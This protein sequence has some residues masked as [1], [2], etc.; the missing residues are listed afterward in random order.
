[1]TFRQSLY[2]SVFAH[3]LAL[4][5]AIAFAQFTGV[6]ILRYPD[7]VSVSLASLGTANTSEA[8]IER[9]QNIRSHLE[10]KTFDD[11]PDIRNHPAQKALEDWLPEH[12]RT[13]NTDLHPAANEN[14]KAVR[15]VVNDG[16]NGGGVAQTTTAIGTDQN[17]SGSIGVISPEQWAAIDSAIRRNKH[18]PRIARERGIQGA[19]R[20][21]FILNPSGAVDKIEILQSSGS[22]VLD[23]ASIQAVYRAAPMPY[24]AGWVEIPIVYVLK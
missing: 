18:Y 16:N 19:V 24:V 1:M 8:D 15:S 2:I 12:Q 5:G 21:R 11:K 10:Q 13:S 7:V 4:G 22:D 23:N 3:L 9:H 17:G 6:L 20:L 14:D